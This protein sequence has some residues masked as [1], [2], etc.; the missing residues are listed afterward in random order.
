MW[1]R[2]G[3]PGLGKA[4]LLGALISLFSGLI[5]AGPSGFK[6]T[7]GAPA[8]NYALVVLG[9]GAALT[10]ELLAAKMLRHASS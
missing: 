10:F 9:A 8:F 2:A 1:R 5:L 7:G 4:L 6:L 3:P